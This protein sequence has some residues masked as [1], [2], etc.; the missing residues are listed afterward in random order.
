MP[1]MSELPAKAVLEA[2][3]AGGV[4]LYDVS[5]VLP[6]HRTERYA[7]RDAGAIKRVYVHHSGAL[8][9]AGYAGARNSAAYSVAP[10]VGSV[11]GWP[12]AAYHFWICAEPLRDRDG[13]ICVLR[14]NRDETRCYHTGGVCNAHGVGVVLQGNTSAAPLAESHEE[15]LEALLPWLRRRH[16]LDAEWLSWH[17]ESKRF[18]APKNKASCPGKHAESWLGAYRERERT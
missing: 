3:L 17:A 15:C 18:G 5:H 7:V 14:M 16:D 4:A 9:A 8:G 2:Q 12:G 1:S 6:V 13:N 11:K 10:R